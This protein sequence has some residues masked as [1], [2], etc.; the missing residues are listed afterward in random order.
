MTHKKVTI[1]LKP[2]ARPYLP[3]SLQCA[4]PGATILYAYGDDRDL[5]LVYRFNDFHSRHRCGVR[6]VKQSKVDND[7][8]ESRG[9]EPWAMYVGV[10]FSIVSLFA[11]ERDEVECC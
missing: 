3:T 1:N 4:Q 6:R 7:C 8:C 9:A 2:W 5:E 11:R 10:G